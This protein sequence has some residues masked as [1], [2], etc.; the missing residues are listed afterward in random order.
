MSTAGRHLMHSL[1]SVLEQARESVLEDSSLGLRPSQLRV[2][3]MVPEQGV[4]VSDLA[5][6]VGMTKQGIGQ[7]VARLVEGGYLT[8]EVHRQDRRVRVV[9]RTDRGE[10]ACHLLASVLDELESRWASR[11]GAAKYQEFRAVLDEL[12]DLRT[13]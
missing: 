10:D 5:V 6:L 9:R 8:V 7:F 3:D 4:T 12:A 2:L 11:I 13:E 1:G